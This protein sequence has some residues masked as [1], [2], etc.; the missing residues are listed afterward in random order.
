MPSSYGR[1]RQES[2]FLEKLKDFFQST[3]RKL[4]PRFCLLIIY[5]GAAFMHACGVVYSI[6]KY[7]DPLMDIRFSINN[8]TSSMFLL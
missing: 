6:L 8:A 4:S 2:P 1:H 5:V 7:E 3:F